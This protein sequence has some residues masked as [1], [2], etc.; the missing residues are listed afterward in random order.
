MDNVINRQC[1]YVCP[2]YTRIY[3]MEVREIEVVIQTAALLEAYPAIILALINNRASIPT[4]S[5]DVSK[6]S[7]VQAASHT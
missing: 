2:F 6:T 7:S 3:I 4:D 5:V 1:V